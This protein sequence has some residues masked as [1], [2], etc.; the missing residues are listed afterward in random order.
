MIFIYLISQ[1]S[2]AQCSPASLTTLWV[3]A[4]R[5]DSKDLIWSRLSC[6][7]QSPFFETHCLNSLECLG[8]YQAYPCVGVN[9][10]IYISIPIPLL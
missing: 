2:L 8:D 5:A 1:V 9:L 7:V 6:L 10:H 4:I 3:P